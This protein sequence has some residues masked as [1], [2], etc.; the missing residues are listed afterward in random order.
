MNEDDEQE[1]LIGFNNQ[2]KKTSSQIYRESKVL[3]DIR[4]RAFE[5]IRNA[6]KTQD[7]NING[8]FKKSPHVATL[9]PAV[10]VERGKTRGKL[11][12][13]TGVPQKQLETI[14]EVGKLA[15]TGKTKTVR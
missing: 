8:T 13:I 3:D 5:K 4:E 2:R 1:T 7:R 11:S 10:E 6:N 14:I 12:E 15:E 9:P